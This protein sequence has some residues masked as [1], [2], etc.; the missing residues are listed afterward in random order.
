MTCTRESHE[1]LKR[2]VDTFRAA[3]EPR[4]VMDFG[5]GEPLEIANCKY[6]LSTIAIPVRK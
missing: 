4:G 6:C 2:D 3:T 5:D 1:D